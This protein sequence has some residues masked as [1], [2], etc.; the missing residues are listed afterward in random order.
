VFSAFGSR[1][2]GIDFAAF[3]CRRAHS[4]AVMQVES[5]HPSVPSLAFVDQW[6]VSTTETPNELRCIPRTS[7][8]RRFSPAFAKWCDTGFATLFLAMEERAT[9]WLGFVFKHKVDSTITPRMRTS[10]SRIPGTDQIV[11]MSIVLF[12][13][14]SW[15]RA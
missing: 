13:D 2:L 15:E 5:A 12:R 8:G 3:L 14:L 4:E 1:F 7:D 6:R 11:R 9:R 10:W